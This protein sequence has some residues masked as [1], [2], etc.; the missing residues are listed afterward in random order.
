VAAG[1]FFA[2]IPELLYD[3]EVFVRESPR[4]DQEIPLSLEGRLL[5]LWTE[6]N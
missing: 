5:A 3:V 1:A 6:G 4:V 2:L